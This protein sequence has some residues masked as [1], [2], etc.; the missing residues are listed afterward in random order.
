MLAHNS[1]ARIAPEFE[2]NEPDARQLAVGFCN[3]RRHYGGTF[4]PKTRDLLAFLGILAMIEGPRVMR[5]G[6]RRS[7]ERKAAVVAKAAEAMAG[8]TVVNMDSFNR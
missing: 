4:D 7:A 3:W 5:A 2:I 1:L 8:G 6:N